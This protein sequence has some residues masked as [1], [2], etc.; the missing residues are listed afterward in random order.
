MAETTTPQLRGA[1]VVGVGMAVPDRVVTNEEIAARLGVDVDW[2]IR[3]TGTRERHVR[4]PGERL[5][6]LA[7]T[8]ARAALDD[9]HI[10]A[11]RVDMVIV[12]TTSAE[13]MSPHAAPLVA[14]DLGAAGAAALDISS[15]C[16][17]FL[18][19]LALAV[20]QVESCRADTVVVIGAD[21]LSHYLDPADRGSAMLFGDGAGAVVVTATDGPTRIGPVVLSSD[22][23]ARDL[24]R[25]PRGERITMDGP[26]VYKRAVQVM[27]DV[28]TQVLADAGLELAD[29]DLFAYH[30]ANS[31]IIAAVGS[32]LHL[33][34]GR[35]I[36]EVGR[37]ANTSAAS[38]PIALAVARGD[39]RLV[40]GTRVLLA[41][42]GAGLVW[43]GAVVRWGA[44]AD[45]PCRDD[46]GRR[47]HR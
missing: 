13:E 8:A 15:A 46:R 2:I 24:I 6:R 18:A 39:G 10:T 32:R 37:F 45:D 23:R 44:H 1:A 7:T 34:P 16:V 11:D 22:G 20:G 28:T 30:Q 43:G 9:A 5:D 27:A 35:V 4:A 26:A 25:L 40:D 42:F 41:A 19:G 12:A 21:A 47:I 38:L 14:D 31:R 17:G 29:V 36:D 33:D 3:R